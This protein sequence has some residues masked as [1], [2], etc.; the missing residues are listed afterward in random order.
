MMPGMN[1]KQMKKMMSQMGIQQIDIPA[2]EVIIKTKEKELI[3]KN[4]E[5]A[6]VKAMGQETY[7]IIGTPIERK[8]EKFTEEDIL[9]VANQAECTEEEARAALEETNGDL[10]EAIIKLEK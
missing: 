6:K 3:F 1:P 7:Q 5:V 8:L 4:P 2:T 9:T 10:A